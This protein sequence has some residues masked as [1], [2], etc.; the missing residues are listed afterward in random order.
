MNFHR[1]C[2]KILELRLVF[3]QLLLKSHVGRIGSPEVF[4]FQVKARAG[5]VEA[6]EC[7]RAK[8][9]VC[10]FLEKG[11]RGLCLVYEV[12][13]PCGDG[14][15]AAITLQRAGHPSIDAVLACQ[16]YPLLAAAQASVERRLEY[17]IL[18]TDGG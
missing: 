16:P 3:L 12:R 10:A 11:G 9:L 5:I 17:K 1:C 14:V 15:Q 2:T 7:A 8:S 13:H 6:I 18:R 4:A